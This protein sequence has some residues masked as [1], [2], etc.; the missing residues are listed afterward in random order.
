M[1]AALD[2]DGELALVLGTERRLAAGLDLA[3]LGKEGAQQLRILVVHVV[4]LIHT[5]LA[6]AP[7]S[8]VSGS[9]P[10]APRR[11]T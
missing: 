2:G 3:A 11:R 4:N 1:A 5:E 8:S 6:G 7:P 10:P 9:R